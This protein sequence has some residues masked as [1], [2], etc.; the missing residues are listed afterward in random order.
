MVLPKFGD[1][2]RDN[3]ARELFQRLLPK[4]KIVQLEVPLM[5]ENGGGIHCA[6]QQMP[7]APGQ[8][9]T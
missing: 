2:I 7:K 5:S 9:L 6:T 3:D 8:P 4:R 1:P